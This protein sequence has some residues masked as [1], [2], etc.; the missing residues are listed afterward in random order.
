M[1]ARLALL[2]EFRLSLLGP[3]P[4]ETHAI[5]RGAR[6]LFGAFATLLLVAFVFT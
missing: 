1:E 2:L 5:G 4:A 6:F 3:G